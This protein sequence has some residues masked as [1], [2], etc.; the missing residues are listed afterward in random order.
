MKNIHGL[1]QE[2]KDLL[3]Q[4]HAILVK[5]R[6]ENRDMTETEKA[7]FAANKQKTQDV[8]AQIDRIEQVMDAEREMSGVPV[9]DPE[10]PAASAAAPK[11]AFKSLGEQLIAVRNASVSGRVD[12]R[13][14]T[15]MAG[16]SG[17]SET[18]PSDGGFLVQTDFSDQLF[19]RTYANGQI[20]SRVT[21]Y[22]ISAVSNRLKINAIDEDSRVDGSRWG[23]VQAFW[24][25]EADALTGS[26]PKFRQIELALNKLTGLCYATDE[27]LQDAAALQAVIMD[28]FPKEFTFKIEDAIIS[29][30][31]AGQ[32]LGLLNSGAV[33]TVAKDSGDS[34]ATISTN[35]VLNMYKRLFATSRQNAVWLMNQD[36]EAAL[37]PLTLG[38]GT[39]VQLLYFPPGTTMNPDPLYGRMLGKPV[40]PVEHCSTLGTPGDILLVDLSQYLLADKGAPE[41]ASSIHVRFLND[42]T[43]FRFIVRADGQPAWKKPLTPKNGSS[44][45]SPFISLATRP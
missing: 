7:T 31:G 33:I 32:P 39:A 30:T 2:K 19:Q 10:N 25:N 41:A 11:K 35:D 14:S 6:D 27:L 21:R 9:G 23:G 5:C 20:A 38:T 18:V 26:K 22:P 40:I 44:T 42:E 24:A 4:N 36:V 29:G 34:T 15:L 17:T 37:Y 3:S 1:R 45:Q 13:L 16:P 8:Q 43:T 28:A 12:P